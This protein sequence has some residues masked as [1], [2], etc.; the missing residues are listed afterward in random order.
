MFDFDKASRVQTRL[1]SKLILRQNIRKVTLVA[2]ADFGYNKK[3]NK[4]C[5]AIVSIKI[6]EFEI[7]EATREVE[8]VRIPY[9]PEYLCFRE[10]PVFIRAFRKLEEKPDLTLI[11]GN[12]IAHP[13][14]MGLA[15]YVGVVLDVPTVGCAKSPFYPFDLPPEYRGA[16]TPYRD[17]KGQTVG[18]CLRTSFSVR[19][20]FVSP[21][22]RSDFV[23]AREA[24][25]K[26]SQYR[27]PEPLRAAHR[28]AK[29]V[30]LTE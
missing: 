10:G 3:K 8:E 1:A 23:L 25:L 20:I 2:G 19:P 4:I 14:K 29:N 17:D 6:P 5:A 13:R 21:G 28:L 24:V 18:F 26:C 11:D 30:F 15:S 7:I 16:Y 9:V 27:I 22:H 12:G